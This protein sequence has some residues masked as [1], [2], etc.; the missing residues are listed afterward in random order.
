MVHTISFYDFERIFMYPIFT[1]FVIFALFTAI[2]MRRTSTKSLTGAEDLFEKE[3][4]ANSVRKMPLTDIDFVNVDLSALPVIETEDEYLLEKFKTL[5]FLADAD[6]KIANLSYY[7]NTDLKFKY[8]VANLTALTEYDQ[9]F[10]NLCRC[11]FD[12]GQRLY[13]SDDIENA[14][15]YLE[16]GINCGTDLKSHYTLL[17]D[18]YEAQMGYNKIVK[19]IHNA[20]SLN[21]ALKGAIIRDL[22]A[23]LEGTNYSADDE[24]KEL[25][26]INISV[27]N[28]SERVTD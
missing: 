10:T 19:L 24:V 23:R 17:A 4:E 26:N 20:E 7:S 18:I 8:G 13:K 9:N 25:E 14:Q 27:S 2:Y 6:T 5:Q 22:T 1:V 16:Y 11:I 28:A 15:A 3:R 12:I 21:T